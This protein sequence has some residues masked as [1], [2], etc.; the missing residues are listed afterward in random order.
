MTNSKFTDNSEIDNFSKETQETKSS[1]PEDRPVLTMANLGK[2]GR[3]GNQVF[4]YAFLKI[5]AEKSGAQVETSPW[6]G[7][8]LFG[9]NDAPISKKLPFAMER[10]YIFEMVW[11]LLPELIPYLEK[12]SGTN[13]SFIGVEDLETG[14][15]NV[16][17]WGIFQYHTKYFKSHQQYFRSLFE[18]VSD[19]KSSLD[20]GLNILRSKGKTIVG[21][22][23][24]RGDYLEM[25]MYAYSLVFPSKW[26]CEWLE[27]IWDEL[28]DPVLFLCSNDL[29]SIIDDF[30]KFSPVTGKDLE[31]K[32]PERLK[33]L[34]IDFYIDFFMLSNCD[35]VAISNSTFSFASCMLNRQAKMFV[36]PHWNFSSKFIAFDPWD[37]YPTLWL[38]RKL[39][40][41]FADL[42]YTTYCT[43][44]IFYMLK[45]IFIY[46]P[47]NIAAIWYLRAYWGYQ[48]KGVIG[49]VKTFLH[50]L[51]WRSVWEPLDRFKDE[52]N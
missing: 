8:T 37:S 45:S 23:V 12:L 36:R 33:D 32:L 26:Y 39:G 46:L 22:H 6:I 5:C 50:T 10:S 20:K 15:A 18:P 43:Q 17:L 42:V 25:P 16:N 34:N 49:L 27:S 38:D 21:I 14:R 51:G 1:S 41:S 30:K 40:K 7:Q 4:E 35:V 52:K 47:K 19:L 44:G 28:E 13:I 24:R 11:E 31:I 3:F 29:G 48:A 2:F 9:H